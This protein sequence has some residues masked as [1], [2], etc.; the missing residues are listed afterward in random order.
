[1]N[2]ERGPAVPHSE[3]RPGVAL[4]ALTGD[5]DYDT[6]DELAD[7]A[8]AALQAVADPHELRLDCAGLGFCD[9]YGLSALLMLRRRSAA[10]GIA[11]RLDNRG[12]ALDR[13]LRI[14]ST[15]EHLTGEHPADRA[16]RHDT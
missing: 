16:E 5:L 6:S 10:A 11:L 9:S 1:M 13:L 12:R 2:D 7:A 4:V 8:D 15:W 14:T 3:P